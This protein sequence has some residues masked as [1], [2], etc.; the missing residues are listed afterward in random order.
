VNTQEEIKPKDKPQRPASGTVERRSPDKP[1][2][3]RT[4]KNLRLTL[5]ASAWRFVLLL[6]ELS[7]MSLDVMLVCIHVFTGL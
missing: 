2:A 1:G 6:I 3:R 7:G 5:I 4:G